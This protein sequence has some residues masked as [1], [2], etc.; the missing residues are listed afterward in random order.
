ELNACE[1]L[2]ILSTSRHL[3]VPLHVD[4]FPALRHSGCMAK[5]ALGRGLGAL[6]GGAPVA[7]KP[8]PTAPAPEPATIV[9]PAPQPAPEAV[10]ADVRERVHRVPLD[11]IRPCP[12]QPRKDFAPEAL[13]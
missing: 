3:S 10:A 5:P 1:V 6:L 9:I 8:A 13:R 7:H 12:L 4:I 2:L 11:R